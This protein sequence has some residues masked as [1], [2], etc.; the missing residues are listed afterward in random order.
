MM[1]RFDDHPVPDLRPMFEPVPG[2]RLVVTTVWS[3][4]R[5]ESTAMWRS[6]NCRHRGCRRGPSCRRRRHLGLVAD[7][8]TRRFDRRCSGHVTWVALAAPAVGDPGVRH[9]IAE[10]RVLL[11]ADDGTFVDLGPLFDDGDAL[12]SRQWA[13][14][15]VLDGDRL[16][17]YYTAAGVV[18]ADPPASGSGW[19]PPRRRSCV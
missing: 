9:N 19:P 6:T 10:H 3:P 15:T 5:F 12:G 8:H 16:H 17:A 11:A 1:L 18:G 7:S 13:G 4:A 14:S 2:G